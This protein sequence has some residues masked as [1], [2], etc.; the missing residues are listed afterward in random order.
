MLSGVAMMPAVSDGTA[1]T[2]TYTG[3]HVS[4]DNGDSWTSIDTGYYWAVK[5]IGKR[6]WAVGNGGKITRVEF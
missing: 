6:A 4:R 2:A 1:I 3:L 5:A